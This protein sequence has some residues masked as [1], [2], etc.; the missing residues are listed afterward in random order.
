MV[1]GVSYRHAGKNDIPTLARYHRLMFEEMYALGG[2]SEDLQ[3]DFK[4]LEQAQRTKLEQQLIDGSCMAWV[5][6]YQ[7][8]LVAGGAVS[9]IN[10]VP[11]PEDP[12]CRVAFLHSVYTVKEMRG[13]GIASAIVDL[14]IDHCRNHGLRRIQLN[15]SEAGRSVYWRKGFKTLEQ[16]MI[17]WLQIPLN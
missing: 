14:L 5:A 9:I 8:Q 2:S 15:A 3:F 11:V 12:S 1:A 7:D 4:A 13:R 6:E 16:A 10:T 17:L